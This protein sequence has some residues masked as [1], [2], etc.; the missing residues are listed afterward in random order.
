MRTSR[1]R[2]ASTQVDFSPEEQECPACQHPWQERYHKQRWSIRLDQHV[3]VV[4]HFL[5]CGNTACTRPAVVSRPRQEDAL[6]LRGDAFGLEVVARRGEWRAPHTWS[7]PTIRDQLQTESP[8]SIS[9]TEVSLLCEVC[10]AWVTTVAPHDEE[11]I[12]QWSTWDGII[13]AMDGVQPAKSHATRALLRDV[14]SG[15]V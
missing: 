11:L 4:S 7:M 15:R 10:L 1:D 12:R 13:L 3:N 8:R 6:A 5:E 2:R 9:R 14:R